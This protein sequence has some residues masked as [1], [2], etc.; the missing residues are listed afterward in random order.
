MK[1]RYFI[2]F[3]Y[4]GTRYHGWQR[5]QNAHTVQ[6]ELE[7]GLAQLLTIEVTTTGQGR[8]DTG[9]HARSCYAHFDLDKELPA[10]LALRLN[11]VLPPDIAIHD[12]FEVPELAHARY[13]AVSRSYAY[14]MHFM[15]DPFGHRFSTALRQAPDFTRIEKAIPYLLKEGDF[16]CF[17]RTGGGN[18]TNRCHVTA[19]KWIQSDNSQAIFTITADRFLRNMVRAIVGTLLDVGYGKHEPEWLRELMG[20]GSRSKAGQSAPAE[21]LILENVEYPAWVFERRKH[22]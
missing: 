17:A 13:S 4:D 12:I 18:T 7:V 1:R 2:H 10:D 8:T 5:Q 3:A 21:G 14:H 6:A 15:K 20:E 9:V 19:A 22:A 11:K 16:G